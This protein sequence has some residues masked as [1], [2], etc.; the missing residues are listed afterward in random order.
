MPTVADVINFIQHVSD[1]LGRWYLISGWLSLRQAISVL[2]IVSGVMTVLN[3]F[4]R[5]DDD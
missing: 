5:G 4:F 2:F 1:F 3:V